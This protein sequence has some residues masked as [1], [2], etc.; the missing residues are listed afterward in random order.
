ME[1]QF[2]LNRI[3]VIWCLQAILERCGFRILL[4]VT[5]SIAKSEILITNGQSDIVQIENIPQFYAPRSDGI[6]MY[7]WLPLILSIGFSRTILQVPLH[8]PWET[9]KTL[10]FRCFCKGEKIQNEGY[11][12]STYILMIPI[13]ME[14]TWHWGTLR[15]KNLELG[16]GTILQIEDMTIYW[17]TT[18]LTLYRM[19]WTKSFDLPGKKIMKT[20]N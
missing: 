9:P 10:I 14:R 5:L 12:W 15:T 20:K 13:F 4:S 2:F 3:V 6:R 8:T 11:A 1:M 18:I 17:Y 19:C 16:T 7:K